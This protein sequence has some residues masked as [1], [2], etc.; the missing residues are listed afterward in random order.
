[1]NNN[2]SLLFGTLGGTL[3]GFYASIHWEDVFSTILMSIVGAICSYTV[4]SILHRSKNS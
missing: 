3:S 4:S 1:M 2:S